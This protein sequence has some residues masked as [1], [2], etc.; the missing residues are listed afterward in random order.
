MARHRQRPKK[1]STPSLSLC[2]IVRNEA[3]NLPSCLAPIQSVVDEIVLVD[4]GSSDDTKEV[5]RALGARVFEFPWDDDFSA[6]RNESIRHARGDYI[7]WLDADDRVDATEVEKLRALKG[8]FPRAKSHAYYLTIHNQSAVDGET[9]FRQLRIFPNLP[10]VRF[11]GKIHEQVYYTLRPKGV[12]F[13][14]TDIGIRHIGYH[15]ASSVVRKSERNLKILMKELEADP[16]NPILRYHAARTLSGIGRHEEAIFH[17][18]QVTDDPRIQKEEKP[19]FLEASLLLGKYYVEAKRFEEA[20]SVFAHLR[21]LFP[22]Q[23]LVHFGLGETLFLQKEFEGARRAL[24]ASLAHP[25]EVTLF[26]VNLQRL[27]FYQHYLL[28]RSYLETGE[29]AKAKEMFL[30][31]LDQHPNHSKS[32]QSLGLLCLQE[33]RFEEAASFYERA[34][35]EGEATPEI[36]AS[37]GMLS[38]K[39]GRWNKAEGLFR[40]LLDLAPGA[41]EPLLQL[42]DLYR[43]KR[44]YEKAIHHFLAALR[45]VPHLVEARL[46]LSDIYFRLHEV[47]TLIEQCD[48][49]LRCLDL[50]RDRVLQDLEELGALFE[51]IAERLLDREEKDACLEALKVAFLISPS[52]KRMERIV[53]MAQSVGKT[54]TLLQDLEERLRFHGVEVKGAGHAEACSAKDQDPLA[55]YPNRA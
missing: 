21:E 1:R 3:E 32:L 37:L 6:A 51:E 39:M 42:G 14:N 50:P 46:A 31:S 11:Q 40:R 16:G 36:L 25:L 12:T 44:D 5:G 49:L 9:L 24:E 30:R 33:G 22:E 20:A 28:G 27:R 53:A 48:A 13:V 17:M 29:K 23:S 38:K 55:I 34:V 7:L 18:K 19:F 35:N 52:L 47:D 15:D 54:E 41:V 8:R 10:G 45:E 26:P 43:S 2:M 4:T